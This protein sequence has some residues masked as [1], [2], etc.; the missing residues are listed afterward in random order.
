[1]N[2][3]TISGN[4]S[5]TGGGGGVSNNGTF[6]M[7][8]GTISGNKTD[9]YGGGGVINSGT[10]RMTGGTISGN[11]TSGEGGGVA[12]IFL[13]SFVKTGGTI[14]ATNSAKDSK[15][16]YYYYREK[17]KGITEKRNRAAGPNDNL[18]SSKRG[19]AGGWE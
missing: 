2:G 3:G 11:T 8:G 14:D 1:M 19:R 12:S 16:A 7:S 13:S 4:T 15:V 9:K 17:N 6:T 10:F 5:K 18:D